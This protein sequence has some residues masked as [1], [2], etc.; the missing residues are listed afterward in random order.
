MKK[1]FLLCFLSL[2][3]YACDVVE[4]TSKTAHELIP[5]EAKAKSRE[6]A[7]RQ[8]LTMLGEM[9]KTYG[10]KKLYVQCEQAGDVTGAGVASGAEIPLDVTDM[11][12]TA[13]NSVGGNIYYIPYNPNYIIGQARAGY[14]DP[15][16]KVTPNLVISG[17][18]TEFDRA[19]AG[20]E[21][22]LDFTFPGKD[23]S[24]G[25][26]GGKGENLSQITFDINLIDYETMT[27]IPKMQAV[28]TVLV[29]RGKADVGVGFQIFGAAL[30]Y[31]S[32]IKYVQ[33]RHAAVRNLVELSILEVIG[34]YLNLP[35]WRYLPEQKPDP[36]V[37]DN[38]KSS[39]RRTDQ[40]GQIITI[41]T[42]LTK[43]GY[44]VD[45][46]GTFD[47]TTVDALK[48]FKAK[49]MNLSN[50]NI[51]EDTFIALYVNIPIAGET[52]VMITPDQPQ[53]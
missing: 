23:I 35:Y 4:T 47:A 33:G 22:K 24:G 19:L 36:L 29:T 44:K 53:S 43:Y 31:T 20:T 25:L 51:D 10:T 18:I 37:I 48:K 15:K 30:G 8:P 38:L 34:R 7:M 45:P 13:V 42:L 16:S 50:A 11:I 39:F 40:K 3:V 52:P 41:Q 21:K 6:T 12:K 1:V 46:T 2:F 32:G 27:M 9:T 28:N 14:K 49:N 26:G 17:A 5:P